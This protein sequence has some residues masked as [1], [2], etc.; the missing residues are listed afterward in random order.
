MSCLISQ[1]IIDHVARSSR[2]R[3]RRRLVSE[4]GKSLLPGRDRLPGLRLKRFRKETD[5]LDVWFDS[6]VS[7]AAVMEKRDYLAAPRTCTWKGA[8]S[9]GAGSTARFSVRVGTRGMRRTE[10]VLTHGFVVDGAGK[11]MHKSAGNVIAPED[12]IK[13]Y[14]AEILRLWVAGEDYRD[15]IRLSR[16][17]F[18]V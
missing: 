12:V 13:K 2:E 16:R 6:G 18:S 14:G 4:P 17:S 5:I 10:A 8:T 9:T 3:G 15:D 7:H 11:D 1:E